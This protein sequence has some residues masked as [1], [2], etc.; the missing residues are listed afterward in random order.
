MRQ[1]VA[2]HR[3][4]DQMREGLLDALGRQRLLEQLEILRL[5]GPDI[6]VRGVA[7]VAGARMRDVAHDAAF[8][9]AR[10]VHATMTCRL[11]LTRPRGSKTD[12]VITQGVMAPR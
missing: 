2:R 10:G 1:L 8:V 4:A 3:A 5:V 12:F 7:F 6:D 11:G 9:A